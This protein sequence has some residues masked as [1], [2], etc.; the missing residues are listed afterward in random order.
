[1]TL[2][3]IFGENP[4]EMQDVLQIAVQAFLR[5]KQVNLSPSCLFVHQ[6]VG[7]ITAKEQN[8]EGQRRLQEKLDEMTVIAAQQEFCDVSCF[9]DVIRFDVNTHIHYFAHLWEGNPPMAPPNPTYSQNV[10]ELKSKIL[11]AAKKE[12]QGSVL[13]LS[14]LK[15]RISDLWNALLNENFIFSF[16]NS[17]EIAAYKKLETAFSKWTW[18]LRSHILDLQMKLDNKIR[19]GDL[20][21]VTTD[22][23][24]KQ[25]QETS[26][27]ITEDMEKYFRED[28]DCEILVQWK[29]STE[30]KLKELKESLLLETRKKCE[31][32]IEL[33]KNHSKLDER[34]SEYENE[35]L[36]KSRELALSLKAQ[37]P[38]PK[39]APGMGLPAQQRKGKKKKRE[40][41]KGGKKKKEK[42]REKKEE[43]KKKREK[44]KIKKKI[45]KEKGK[46]REKET[47]TIKRIGKFYSL[48]NFF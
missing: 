20:P 23:L 1:M 13:R 47:N 5:M 38:L 9:S 34:K 10:Q 44:R 11:Q 14:S 46:G 43:R 39:A 31:N 42:K 29:S 17:V 48:L 36:K 15:A 19:N 24:E 40:G 41:K 33:R 27:A 37:A 2:I 16:K 25:V 21:K 4:S 28:R 3:N 8:M 32:L 18:D 22:Y 26:D 30:L 35:I 7:E 6:N 12:A 45:K